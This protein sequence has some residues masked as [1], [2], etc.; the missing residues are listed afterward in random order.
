MF[1]NGT[2]HLRMSTRELGPVSKISVGNFV[3]TGSSADVL[4]GFTNRLKG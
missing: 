4:S 1:Y 3:V 2:M